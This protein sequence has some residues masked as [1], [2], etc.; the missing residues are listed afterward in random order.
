MRIWKRAAAM[1]KILYEKKEIILAVIVGIFFACMMLLSLTYKEKTGDIDRLYISGTFESGEITGNVEKKTYGKIL[2]GHS[3]SLTVRGHFN[4]DIPYGSQIF[5]YLYGF[6]AAVLVNGEEIPVNENV[7]WPDNRIYMAGGRWQSIYANGIRRDD[8]VEI[9]ITGL[10]SRGGKKNP[11]ILL[12]NL[13]VGDR[14][15]LF[16]LQLEKAALKVAGA[17][18]LLFMGLFL[19]SGLILLKAIRIP[20]SNSY[21]ASG[22]LLAAGGVC[23]LI[24]FKYITLICDNI[25]ILDILTELSQL[26]ILLFLLMS[27]RNY[28][29][30]EKRYYLISK[31]LYIWELLIIIYCPLRL[32][33]IADTVIFSGVS[34]LAAFFLCLIAF[35]CLLAENKGQQGK[36]IKMVLHSG[37]ILLL[38]IL[39][40]I[41]NC[42]FTQQYWILLF[43]GGLFYYTVIQIYAIAGYTK[44]RMEKA[45]MAD[46]LEKELVQSQ[47]SILLSQIQPH[48]IYN[49]LVV[50]KHLCDVDT[51]LAKATITEFALYLRG[52]MDSLGKKQNIPFEEEM[53]HVDVYLSLERKRFED[54]I[55]VEKDIRVW[56]FLLPTLSIQPIVENSIRHGITKKE[57]G[58]TIRIA[59]WE[60]EE[61]IIVE[62]SDDG[63]FNMDYQGPER[64][65]HIG[66][67]NVRKRI[68]VMC[69]GRVEVG[70]G[71]KEGTTV[72]IHLPKGDE[73]N[74]SYH[75]G[76]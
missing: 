21:L 43:E 51:S 61:E 3:D 71:E 11:G 22:G 15:S 14:Y 23:S 29:K 20:V 45:R 48:F 67:D 49:V 8:E 65:S 32:F 63:V 33:G 2:S 60:N 64:R 6:R 13:Y 36:R 72:T 75:S 10:L 62:I 50:I 58:G 46:Q 9:R 74:E 47:I 76:R 41:I 57:D 5:L 69:G 42:C 70:M 52:N 54:K 4:R 12:D 17:F 16:R 55:R 37:M 39:L 24:D 25:F 59:T 35:S 34:L 26:L 68:Q 44:E 18:I 73:E 30:E 19:I 7:V 38:C 40:A 53:K 28:V 31:L 1:G 27:L 66:I 56:D